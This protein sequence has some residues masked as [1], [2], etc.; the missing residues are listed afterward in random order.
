M[1]DTSPT[2]RKKAQI[3]MEFKEALLKVI[4]GKKI[5][6]TTWKE[7]TYA[8]M[9]TNEDLCILENEKIYVWRV[10]KNDVIAE[11]FILY[12]EVN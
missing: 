9:D 6:R 1:E 7:D 3:S 4:N 8:F 10:N 12:E 5:R 11:D 2:P